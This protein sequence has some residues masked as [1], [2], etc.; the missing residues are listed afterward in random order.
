MLKTENITTLEVEKNMLGM[1]NTPEQK[2]KE[3]KEIN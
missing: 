1:V 3:I 2:T